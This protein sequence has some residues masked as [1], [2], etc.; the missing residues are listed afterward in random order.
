MEADRRSATVGRLLGSPLL[1]VVLALA[2]ALYAGLDAVRTTEWPEPHWASAALAVTSA[3]FL[4]L[5]RV[6]PLVAFAGALGALSVAYV[7]LGHFEAGSSVLIALVAAYSVGAHGRNLPFALA[8][9]AGF[10]ATTGLGQPAPEAV[11]DLL[12]SCVALSLPFAVGLTARRLRGRAQTAE[13]RTRTLEREQQALAEA[14]AEQER[15]RI[16]RELHDIVSHSLG[17]VVLQAGAAEQ[18][19]SHDPDKTREALHLIRATGQQAIAEMGTLVRLIRDEPG[20]GRDPQPT[21]ADIDRLATSTRAAGLEVQVRTEGTV[22]ELPA[23]VELNAYRVVQEGLTNALKHTRQAKVS[24]VLR[25]RP[26]G[27]EVE[28][29][30]SG[31][32]TGQGPGSRRGLLGLRERVA[33]FGGQFQAGRDPRGG[34]TV[35]ASFPT[36]S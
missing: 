11:A 15:R 8:G 5:R 13:E 16:A 25:Y 35:R 30:D 26:D 17:V 18:V 20:P 29:C 27:I 2:L 28:V 32:R 9:I 22:R 7:A 33:V 36:A 14:A 1:D 21:L 34:W 10:A 19:L 23:T 6:R 31:S 3:A 12:W 4:A 24:V